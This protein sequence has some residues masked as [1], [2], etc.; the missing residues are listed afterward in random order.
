MMLLVLTFLK[1]LHFVSAFEELGFF[2]EL[3]FTSIDKL[4]F[5]LN[6]YVIV[7]LCFT[8]MY[9]VIGNQPP[10]ALESAIGL[11]DFGRLFLFVWG[12]GACTFG[13]AYYPRLAKLEPSDADEHIFK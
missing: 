13:L 6:S 10:E 4:K 7:G 3:L 11:G 5:F 2:I 1:T 8:V 12:D 9:Q